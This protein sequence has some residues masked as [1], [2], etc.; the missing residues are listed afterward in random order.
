MRSTLKTFTFFLEVLTVRV[1]FFKFVGSYADLFLGLT[2]RIDALD[3]K[4]LAMLRRSP[5]SIPDGLS[6][7]A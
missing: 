4:V 7:V 2:S 1:I 3:Y 6:V 5:R